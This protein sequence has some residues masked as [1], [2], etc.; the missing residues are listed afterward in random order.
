[1]KFEHYWNPQLPKLREVTLKIIPEPSTA[2]NSLLTGHVD[3]IPRLE[4]DYLHQMENQPNLTIIDSPMNLVQ[5]MA[6]NNSVAPFD[7]IRVRQAI[8]YAI[9]REA[10]IQGA[11]WGKGTAIGSNLSPAMGAWYKDMTSL[12]TY[13][14]GKAKELLAEAG[15]PDGFT[16]TLHLPAPY[17]LH[18]S[19]GEIITDQL[20]AVG[21][22]L[23]IQ[24]IEWGA[25]LEQINSKRDYQ[26]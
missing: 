2:V 19:A 12:Y 18:R 7:D 10:I 24:V 23:N 11:A 3:L 21:I 9:N 26:C 20:A 6:I 22:N 5:L 15:Y 17:P 4:P 13:N 25:W 8:N 1:V 16:T 14:P